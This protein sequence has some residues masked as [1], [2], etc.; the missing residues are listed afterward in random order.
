LKVPTASRDRGLGTGKTDTGV[1]LVA[2]G[3]WGRT[4]LDWNIG[5]SANDLSQ[6]VFGDDHWFLG[7][8]VRHELSKR[9]TIIG[10]TFALLPQGDEGGSVNVHVSVGA[11]LI[12]REN[13]LVSALIGSAAGRDSPDLTSY[14]GFTLTY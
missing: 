4:C 3:C 5:Y 2:T 6:T 13:F 11:Q 8:A 9:W 12:V 10:E 7:Q 14:L 1:V